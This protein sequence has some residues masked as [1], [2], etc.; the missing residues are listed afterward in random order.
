[1]ATQEAALAAARAAADGV[2][3][4]AKETAKRCEEEHKERVSVGMSD[5]WL[6]SA[7]CI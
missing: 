5:W 7:I 3:K 6:A 2:A 4:E 1:M